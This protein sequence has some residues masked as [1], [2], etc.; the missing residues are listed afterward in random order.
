MKA[1]HPDLAATPVPLRLAW[2][3]VGPTGAAVCA[4]AALGLL[5]L[6]WASRIPLS[7]TGWSRPLLAILGLLGLSLF[8]R[9]LRPV[10]ILS[11]LPLYAALWVALCLV[12]GIGTYYASAAGM[13]LA[14]ATFAGLDSLA[15][16]DWVAWTQ[17][18]RGLPV[19]NWVLRA[20]YD[21]LMPQ[22]IA[23]LAVLA[24]MRVH[25]RNAEFLLAA[26]VSLLLTVVISAWMPALGPWVH[27]G[28][29]T[30]N[31]SDT[32]YVPHVLAMR[33]GGEAAFDLAKL[34][35]IVCFPSFHTVLAVL[36]VHAHRGLR[37]SR[38]PFAALNGLMLLSVPSEGGHYL[39]DM[40]AG[41]LVAA[42]T[43]AAVRAARASG[44]GRDA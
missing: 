24:F 9:A 20:A 23:T 42:L 34:E 26:S 10:Q 12:G 39:A 25:G 37:W 44:P 28:A 22:I 16:F 30:L 11:E 29:G 17:A 5:D 1:S 21:S 27:Y 6:A 13:P 7:F 33:Q 43:L 31:P 32:A 18:V 14:D 3:G 41:A 36:L 35:G 4:M 19:L 8:Y 38:L 15:G 2:G 40:A